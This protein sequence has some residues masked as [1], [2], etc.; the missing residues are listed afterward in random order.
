MLLFSHL[1]SHSGAISAFSDTLRDVAGRKLEQGLAAFAH[2]APAI[3]PSRAGIFIDTDSDAMPISLLIGARYGM[4]SYPLE[5]RSGHDRKRATIPAAVAR[6][7]FL[8]AV[9]TYVLM[10]AEL[11]AAFFQEEGRAVAEEP[12]APVIASVQPASQLHMGPVSTGVAP[13]DTALSGFLAGDPEAA[14]SEMVLQ[15][16]P[17]GTLPWGG[18][19]MLRCAAGEVRSTAHEMILSGC[20]PKWVTPEAAR[21]ELETLLADRPGVLAVVRVKDSYNATLSWPDAPD[22]SLILTI[23]ATGVTSYGAECGAPPE[24]LTSDLPFVTGAHS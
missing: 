12:A 2:R 11:G 13:V 15:Q 3:D 22:R 6:L 14:L 4:Q 7:A 17:C 10:L 19:P 20:E 18:Q 8:G 23:S 21:T 16:I 24:G 9:A 1:R 5:R